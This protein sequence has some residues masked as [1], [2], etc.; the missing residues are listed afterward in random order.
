MTNAFGL[1]ASNYFSDL[2]SKAIGVEASEK[3]VSLLGGKPVPTQVLSATELKFTLDAE[4]QKAAGR[5]D[6]V[7]INP[8]PVDTFYSRGMW[9][10]GTSNVAHL[11][12]NY[13]YAEAG[14]R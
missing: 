2:D 4:A 5:F 13:R 10:T 11:V 14:T 8:A 3:A 9:G 7:V 6:L 12:V 1:G